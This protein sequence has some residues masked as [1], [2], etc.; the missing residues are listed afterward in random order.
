ML[1]S[2]ERRIEASKKEYQTFNQLKQKLEE[3]RVRCLD[4]VEDDLRNKNWKSIRFM[5]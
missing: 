1:I 5:Y 2:R 4:D 3:L